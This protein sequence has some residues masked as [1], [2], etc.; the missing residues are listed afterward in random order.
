[1]ARVST[2]AAALH[3][4]V[5][6]CSAIGVPGVPVF[7]AVVAVV[8]VHSVVS[9]LAVVGVPAVVSSLLL[10]KFLLLLVILMLQSPCSC[11]SI[12][13]S[14]ILDYR[15][16][17]TNLIISFCFWTIIYL[18]IHLGK[19]SDYRLSEPG[20]NYRWPALLSRK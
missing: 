15:T 6:V 11:S 18:L 4:V 12:T 16:A 9:V 1:M 17:T 7:S 19:V 2:I 10:L 20:K 14:N 13:K 8:S 3:A 5:E